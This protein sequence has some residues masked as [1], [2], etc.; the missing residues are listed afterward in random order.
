MAQVKNK[1]TVAVHSGNFHA[2][3]VFSVATLAIYFKD[4][5]KVIRTREEKII[6]KADYILDVGGEYDPKKN[7]FDHHQIKGPEKRENGIPYATFGLIW[8]QFGQKLAGSKEAQEIIDKKLVQPIDADDNA[9]EICKGF[10]LGVKPYTISD[11]IMYLN[12]ICNEKDRDSFFKKLVPWAKEIIKM[13]IVIAKEFL[14]DKKKVE[15]IYHATLD[16]RLIILDRDYDF[17]KILSDYSEPLFVVKPSEEIK[18]WKVYCVKV[19]GERFT[20]RADLP[21]SWASKSGEELAKIT[22]V[23]DAVY[24]H[25]SRYMAIVKS[26]AGAIKLAELA[27][28][29]AEIKK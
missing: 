14:N 19:N 26:K 22:G 17:R 23:D 28:K 21:V 9:L 1:K 16:K 20:N 13:E 6:S 7:R 4:K 15:A 29:E 12:S 8:K 10:I 24:C 11:Y 25:H 18:Q 3:D 5:I 2:D 27:L